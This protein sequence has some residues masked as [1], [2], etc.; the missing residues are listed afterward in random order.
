MPLAH[1][2]S[3]PFPTGGQHN[4][5]H[6]ASEA[7]VEA[8]VAPAEHATRQEEKEEEAEAGHRVRGGEQQRRFERP[9]LVLTFSQRASQTHRQMSLYFYL[10]HRR[11]TLYIVHLT[12]IL[13]CT[14]KNII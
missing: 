1:A 11:F 9:R 5:N 8:A 12:H 2:G 7:I 14:C 13:A 3:R 10:Y 6:Q 4:D